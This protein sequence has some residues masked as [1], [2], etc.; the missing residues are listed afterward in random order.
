MSQA[1]STV[2][3]INTKDVESAM[4]PSVLSPWLSPSPLLSP[5]GVGAEEETV[6]TMEERLLSWLIVAVVD[7]TPVP[8][9]M[10]PLLP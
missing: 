2:S 9:F 4:M 1:S 8:E 3:N 5:V 6:L 7:E 10:E